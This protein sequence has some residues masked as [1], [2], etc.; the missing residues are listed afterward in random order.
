M[1]IDLISENIFFSFQV[2]LTALLSSRFSGSEF[3]VSTTHLKARKG[4]LMASLRNEQA[5]DLIEHLARFSSGKPI[6]C[7]GDFNAEPNEPVYATMT[8]ADELG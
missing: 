5:K 6:I 7:T 8:Q 3:V 4:P 2:A 1:I